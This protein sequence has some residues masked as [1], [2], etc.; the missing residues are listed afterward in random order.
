[1]FYNNGTLVLQTAL[2]ALKI[3]GEV[4]TTPFS[5]VATT[6]AILWE[7]CK[8][9]FVDID[10]KNYCIDATKI[11]SA[12]T[13]RTAAILVT[14]VFGYPCDVEAIESI[15]QKH[16]LRVIYDAAHAFGTKING[17]SLLTY[18]DISTCSFHATK[19]FHT[20]EGGCIVSQNDDLNWQL[21][22]YRHFGHIGDEYFTM[23][24]N[25]KNSEL[26]AALGLC[27]LKYID[28]ILNS[29][30]AQWLHYKA[31][32]QDSSLQLPEIE[33]GIEYNHAYFPVV[34]SSEE[35]LMK[36]LDELKTK[37]IIPRRYFFPSLNTLPYIDYQPCPIAES[38]A[39]RVL[40]LPMYFELT[41]E[42]QLQIAEIIL[43]VQNQEVKC[44]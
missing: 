20:G 36:T 22:L 7:Q 12:I 27:N 25:G 3:T 4:I 40:C 30:K 43:R 39:R 21:Y 33:G 28:E 6:A 37:E 44:A 9:I 24:I 10:G 1:L 19:L 41:K 38:I 42:E 31:I 29:R 2:K 32:L 35:L 23:G 17:R 8:P 13:S 18:G 14:H 15:A 16:D 5:Y 34:F 11:E 26:H